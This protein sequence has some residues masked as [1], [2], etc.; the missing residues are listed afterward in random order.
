V[1]Y[2]WKKNEFPELKFPDGQQIGLVAQDVEKVLPEVVLTDSEGYKSIDYAK[3]T[4]LLIEAVKTQQQQIE[5]Q[6]QQI[7][8][9]QEMLE[10]FLKNAEASKPNTFGMK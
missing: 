6:Q 9:L 4:P 5:A 7:D 3:L 1:S 2:R 10:Q 8:R